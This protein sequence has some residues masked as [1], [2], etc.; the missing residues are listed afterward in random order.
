MKPATRNSASGCRRRASGN[1]CLSIALWLVIGVGVSTNGF[2]QETSS[3]EQ[4]V[5]TALE[6]SPDI[7]AARSAITAAGGQITHLAPS[8]GELIY[9]RHD[10][11]IADMRAADL[12]FGGALRLASW[13]AP[14]RAAAGSPIEIG[15]RWQASHT[16]QR[17]LFPELLILNAAGQPVAGSLAAPQDGF[18]PTWRW[19]PGESVAEQRRIQL[20][21]D[22]APGVY[23]VVARV[24]D[25]A[26]KRVLDVAGSADG[27]ARIGAV[28]IE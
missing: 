25:F 12:D 9:L 14:D 7:R 10:P 6:R 22:L 18:Y 23:Q 16:L 3:I 15:L 19:R 26:A 20:P 28:V 13:A 5:A 21:P 27:M 8:N 4:L 2:A 17:A 24:H 11:S 1:V